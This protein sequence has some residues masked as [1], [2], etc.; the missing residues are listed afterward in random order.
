MFYDLSLGLIWYLTL[1][2]LGVIVLPISMLI[3]R[4]M[5]E[6]GVLLSRL[7]GWLSISF[8]TWLLAYFTPYPFSQLGLFL[9]GAVF[10]G[11][12]LYLLKTRSEWTMQ[13]L[14]H[15]WRTVLNGELLTLLVFFLILLA[16][17]EDPS[18]N[19]TEKPMD[20]MMLSSLIT[21]S[22]IAPPDLWFAGKP[23][24]YHY[25]GYLLHS[26]PAKLTGLETEFAFNLSV[27][28]VAAMAASAAF[29][30]GRALFGRCRW[31]IITVLCTLFIGNIS[32]AVTVIINKFSLINNPS[33]LRWDFLWTTSRVIYDPAETINE[34]PFFAI[35]WADLHPHFSNIPFVLLFLCVS[36]VL[37]HILIKHP[38]QNIIRYHYPLL[39]F[40]IISCGFL[41]P[42]NIFDFPICSAFFGSLVILA[43][44][45]RYMSTR[46]W[47]FSLSNSVLIL[48]PIIG[49]LLVAPFWMNFESPLKDEHPIQLSSVHT[50]LLE[51]LLVFGAHTLVSVIYL[52]VASR[53]FLTGLSKEETGFIFALL[54]ILFIALWSMSGYVIFAFTPMIAVLFWG[55]S[56][57]RTVTASKQETSQQTKGEIFALTAC[58]L[59]WSLVAVCEFIYLKDQ[60]AS[61]RMNT[62]FKFHFPAWLL[63]GISLPYLTYS[64]LKK[65]S[66]SQIKWF[67][68]APV[69]GALIVS[70]IGPFYALGSLYTMPATN[71]V[72]SL[73]GLTFMKTS[74][75]AHYQI[76]QWIREN[77]SP[78]DRILEVPGCGYREENLVSAFTGRETVIGWV[79]HESVWRGRDPEVFSRKEQ[80]MNF[81][82]SRNWQ[83]AKNLL[84]RYDIQ[85][86]IFTSPDPSCSDTFAKLDQMKAGV[87]RQSLKPIIQET[88][89]AFNRLSP[90]ELYAVPDL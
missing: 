17:R 51:F 66:N 4:S 26:V 61:A 68:A 49:F 43:V 14:R 2:C 76:I 63:F 74:Q 15:Q 39:I 47:R 48:L 42:T 38:I 5:P 89:Q 9:V 30:L 8:V 36:Y 56:L 65:E 81:Y 88:G 22:E 6:S 13:R 20:A 53:S 75:P 34:Y 85:Y 28:A 73:D 67:A 58:A 27:P 3:F 83:E 57:Y 1:T 37:F 18:I 60:Y 52:T 19:T 29:V 80:V 40:A 23:I 77:S 11:I 84:E 71:H 69:I 55:F 7:V 78:T 82:T 10:F 24:N 72:V 33:H 59:A 64:E 62:L 44:V 86:I 87:F 46:Q 90:F 16:R 12:S 35:L 54:G 32:A 70:L 31:G 25:G 45:W 41:L 21:S 50:D 79:N